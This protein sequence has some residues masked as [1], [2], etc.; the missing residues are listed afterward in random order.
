MPEGADDDKN[1]FPFCRPSAAR[2]SKNLFHS[3]LG[4]ELR[5]ARRA[6]GLTQ[7]DLAGRVGCC[8]P[9]VRHAEQGGRHVRRIHRLGRRRGTGD[10]GP[11][12]SPW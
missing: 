8:L 10:R 9:T 4:P 1:P 2:M 12:P 5:E 6:V 3:E 11:Q 7:A